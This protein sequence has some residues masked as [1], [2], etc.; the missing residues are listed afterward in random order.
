MR[1]LYLVV[2]VATTL[3]FTPSLRLA[4]VARAGQ[5]ACGDVIRQ[6]NHHISVGHGESPD[7]SLVS[8]EL[9]SSVPWVEHCMRVYGRRPKRPGAESAEAH[10][11]RLEAF[12]DEE[13]EETGPED[14]QEEGAKE[15]PEHPEK[16]RYE[17]FKDKIEPT[18][19]NN[20][21]KSYFPED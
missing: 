16:P 3:L 17:R 15:R 12:E 21:E 19:E 13:P 1:R 18:P 4:S 20:W 8:K 14:V 7:L 10:E 9:G 5:V 6:I 2:L 11:E